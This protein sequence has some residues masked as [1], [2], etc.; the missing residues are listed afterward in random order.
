MSPTT[1]NKVPAKWDAEQIPSLTGKLAVVTGANSGIGYVT[2]LELA[3]HGADVVL[4]C[5][6]D[7]KCQEAA[8]N[9][10]D[11]IASTPAHGRV[12]A[13]QLDVSSLASVAAFSEQFSQQHE[14]LDLLVNNAGVMAIPFEK[15][16]DG[17]E[18]QFATNH[19]GHFALT[20]RLLPL[21]KRSPAARI[22]NVSSLAHRNAKMDKSNIMT[23]E[24]GY[25]AMTVY[26]NTKLYNVL[27]TLELDRRLKASD[28]SNVVAACAH[29][30]ITRTN[31]LT[32][33][34]DKNGFFPRLLWSIFSYF[35]VFQSADM[36]ALPQLYAATA[37]NVQGGDFFGPEGDRKGYPAVEEPQNESRSKEAAAALWEQSEQ[38]AKLQF[39]VK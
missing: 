35:P 17:L 21:L 27:F 34:T 16:A 9:I 13:M 12:S 28:I 26:S 30:G 20:S 24:K 15:T 4:A 11:A 6:N 7:A 1:P 2:A 37:A 8:K 22:V 10:Q 3:R 23:G 33:P 18:M 19:L 36:G 29:P 32:A 5:R 39:E 38:L 25:S 14:R 31:L